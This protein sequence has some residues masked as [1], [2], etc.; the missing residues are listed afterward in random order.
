MYLALTTAVAPAL[1]AGQQQSW[2]QR[3]VNSQY[4]QTH[5]HTGSYLLSSAHLEV[6]QDLPRYQGKRNI[7]YGAPYYA[8][9]Q[10]HRPGISRGVR[11][12]TSLEPPVPY[13]RPLVDTFA[14]KD[15]HK[16]FG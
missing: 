15:V 14:G 7:H 9:S 8:R 6:P 13:R 2:N 12:L 16:R 3:Q 11:L 1:R 4:A 10:L 5:G